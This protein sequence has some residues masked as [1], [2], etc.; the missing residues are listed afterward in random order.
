MLKN[1]KYEAYIVKYNSHAGNGS[2]AS[3]SKTLGIFISKRVAKDYCDK[4]NTK[5]KKEKKYLQQYNQFV[6]DFSYDNCVFAVGESGAYFSYEAMPILKL[7]R[8][9]NVIKSMAKN[10]HVITAE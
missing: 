1:K 9:K 5:L 8:S 4:A 6:R 10:Y 3:F 7:N 2:G